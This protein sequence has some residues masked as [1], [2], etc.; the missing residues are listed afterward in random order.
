MTMAGKFTHEAVLVALVVLLVHTAR[1]I[2][3]PVSRRMRKVVESDCLATETDDESSQMDPRFGH[4]IANQ[5]LP[6][7]LVLSVALILASLAF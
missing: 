4:N 1:D 5:L 3:S 7:S 6:N 2:A